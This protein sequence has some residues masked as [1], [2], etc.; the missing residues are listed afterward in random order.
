M[1][2]P[3]VSICAYIYN[4]AGYL[5]ETIQ[6]ILGQT[7]T[8]FELFILDDGSTDETEAIVANYLRDPRIRYERQERKGRERLHE[9]FNRCL[10]AT[11]GPYVAVANGDDI[12]EPRKLARQVAALDADPT[13]DVVYHS[14]TFIDSAGF[15]MP[16][17][18]DW[19]Q[20]T[21][22]HFEQRLVLRHM[23]A[24]NLIPNPA[25]MFRREILRRVGLQETGWMHDYQFWLKVAGARCRFLHLPERLIRYRFHES[26]HS[27]SQERKARIE[28]EDRQVRRQMRR[29][30]EIE[31]IYPE[32]SLAHSFDTARLAAHFNLGAIFARSGLP[33]Y[34]MAAAEFETVLELAPDSLAAA[35]NAAVC[36]FLSGDTAEGLARLSRLAQI[37]SAPTLHTNLE[38]AL[39][40]ERERPFILMDAGEM[41]RDLA[42]L[43]GQAWPE[44][45]DPPL[46]A[47]FLALAEPTTD[48][49]VLDSVLEAYLGDVPAGSDQALVFITQTPAM[50]DVIATSFAAACERLGMGPEQT[51]EVGIQVVHPDALP[52]IF[53]AQAL[54]ARSILDLSGSPKLPDLGAFGLKS[55][56][57][58]RVWSRSDSQLV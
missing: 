7:Y 25:T 56:P 5:D 57:E 50:E 23:L 49:Q 22:R 34:D 33:A 6:S 3:R 45:S 8:D 1:K 31:D 14:A 47:T 52:S 46:Q 21:P 27:T 55:R 36:R 43:W 12:L 53:A 11:T 10:E 15:E 42:G 29:R 9:T 32:V 39:Q 17:V 44:P 26:S 2:S 13:V 58:V 51:P 18:P 4:N 41:G 54:G 30:Y 28:E 40:A 37:S 19:S 20:L 38:L 16:D 48:S 24:G 35:C